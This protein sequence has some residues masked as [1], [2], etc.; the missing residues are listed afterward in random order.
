MSNKSNNFKPSDFTTETLVFFM[1]VYATFIIE[2]DE[3]TSF[4]IKKQYI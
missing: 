4:F 3:P 1:S 2:Q